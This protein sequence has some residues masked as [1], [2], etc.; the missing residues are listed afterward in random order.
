L[1]GGRL[2]TNGGAVAVCLGAV[3]GTLGVMR[4]GVAGLRGDLAM[5]S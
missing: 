3:A 2:A 4:C 1:G 5:L